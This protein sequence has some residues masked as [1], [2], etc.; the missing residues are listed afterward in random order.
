MDQVDIWGQGHY[1][2]CIRQ[3]C[4]KRFK[5]YSAPVCEHQ[6]PNDRAAS[7]ANPGILEGVSTG[8]RSHMQG[9]GV[10]P[11]VTEEAVIFKSIQ[12]NEN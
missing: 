3:I 4:F 9:S 2:Q 1:L 5:A 7:V 10:E 8:G 11:P 12:S 6:C